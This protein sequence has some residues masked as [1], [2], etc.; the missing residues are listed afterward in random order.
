MKMVAY[1]LGAA[2]AVSVP[3]VIAN[4]LGFRIGDLS[5][6]ASEETDTQ[7]EA[8]PQLVSYEEALA[9]AAETQENSVLE[10][11]MI[12]KRVSLGRSY[13]ALPDT[14]MASV[15]DRLTRLPGQKDRQKSS[16]DH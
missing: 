7:T 3:G 8:A 5:M 16:G 14:T 6:F 12:P 2:T 15:R 4:Q 11:D 1:L 13:V 9:K 10:D